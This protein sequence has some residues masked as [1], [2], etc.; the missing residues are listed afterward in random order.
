MLY[1]EQVHYGMSKA[2]KNNRQPSS[3]N[4]YHICLTCS[5][6]NNNP[7]YPLI[8][9][10]I[11]TLLFHSFAALGRTCTF[12]VNQL[13]KEKTNIIIGNLV[14]NSN[15]PELLAGIKYI[16]YQ[17]EQ[18]SDTEGWYGKF[19][20]FRSIIQNASELWDYSA[21]NI[22]FLKTGNIHAKLLPLGYGK[23]LETIINSE[24]DIDVLFYGGI[25]ERRQ[26]ILHELQAR[27]LNVKLLYDTYGRERD[28]Y[29]A[30]AKIVLNI[31]FFDMAIFESARIHYLIN[32]KVFVIT[33]Q[34]VDNPYPKIDLVCVPYEQLV[35][36]CVKRLADWRNSQM[37]AELNYEQ[38]R[39]YYPMA[40][41]LKKVL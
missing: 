15:L 8:F 9:W 37:L 29:I 39:K 22:E 16:P 23:N 25:N 30:R 11:I 31:H 26:Q 34:S 13:E 5:P 28:Q 33:E 27:G 36:E 32:N 1:A 4:D 3:Y 7:K 17:L 12:K 35:D 10:E 41:L 14:T 19:S 38:F 40:E 24:K 18:L 21:K 2:A 6:E 20:S